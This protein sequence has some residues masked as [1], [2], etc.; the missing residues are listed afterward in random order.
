M[1]RR[2]PRWL[3]VFLLIAVAAALAVVFVAE[4]GIAERR[5]RQELVE[6][7][8]LRTGARVELG[9][10]HLHIWHLHAE[11]DNLTLHGLEGPEMPPLFHADRVDIAVRVLSFFGKQIALDELVVERPELAVRFAK[12]G[13]SNLPS[14][15]IAAS[16][17][18]WNETLFNLRIGRLELRNGGAQINDQRAPLAV[19]GQNFQFRLQYNTASPGTDSY[20]G[21]LSWV[22]VEVAARR[23]LPFRF[24]L[25]SK[26][27]L[28]RNAFDLDELICK[29]PNSEFD[30]RASLPNIAEKKWDFRYRGHLSLADVRTIF[31]E[32]ETPDGI[33]DFSGN[34]RYS[35]GAWTASGHY[36]GRDVRMHD[37]W[38]HAAKLESWGDYD[39]AQN[40]LVVPQLNVRALGGSVTGRLE[41]DL[42]TLE[43]RTKTHL[44]G[45]S[46][47]SALDAVNNSGFPVDTL[48]WDSVMTV[49][50][51]NTWIANFKHFRSKGHSLWSPSQAVATGDMPVGARIDYD[52]SADRRGIL[53]TQ[54]EITTSKTKLDFDGSL[55]GADS[56]LELKLQASDLTDWDDFINDLRGLDAPRRRIA[57][58][59]DWRGRILGPIVGPT[60]SGRLQATNAVYGTLK[61]DEIDGALEYSPDAFRLTNTT[62][63]RRNASASIDLSLQFD[64]DWGFLPESQWT[65]DARVQHAP[66]GEVQEMFSTK[67]PV[68]GYLS[69]DLRAS[70]TREAPAFDANFTLEGINTKGLTFDRL[71]GV[72]HVA[73]DEIRLSHAALQ[74]DSGRITGDFLYRPREKETEFHA[75]G[76]GIPLGEFQVLQNSKMPIGGRLDFQVRGSGPIAAPIAQG[77]LTLTALSMGPETEGNFRG[78]FSSDGKDVHMSIASEMAHGNLNGSVT[79][80][81]N[82]ARQITGSL[83]A[84]RID[85]DPFIIAGLHLKQL[86][87][88][89]SVSG[90][91]SVAGSLRQPDSIE[92]TANIA[93]IGFNYELIQLENDGPVRLIYRRNEVRIDQ[94]HLHG[95]NTDFRLSG[96]ARFDRDRPLH[97]ALSGGVDLRFLKGILPDL[98][99]QGAAQVNVSIGGTISKP[100]ITGNAS[101]RDASANYSDFPVGLSHV[102]GD[103]VFDQS[104][105]LFERVIAQSGGG[106][107][108]LDGSVTYGEG[109][110]RYIVNANT[111]QV[112]IRYPA[113]MS[114]LVGGKL[115]LAGSSQGSVLSGQI[116]VKR[117]LFSEGVD[118]A[119][120]FATAS[121]T[122]PGPPSSSPFLRNLT[123]DV[124]GRTSPGAQ[125][126]WTGAQIEIDGDVHLRG[127]WDRPVLLGHVHLLGGQMVFR[128]NTFDLTRGDINFANPFRLDPVLNVEATSTISQYQVTINFSG[129]ASRLSLNY[130]SDPPL[131]DSDIIALLAIGSPGEET[132]LRSQTSGSQNYGATALLSEAISS[133]LGGRIERLFGISHFRVDP[134]L[135]GTATESNAAARVTIEQQVTRDLTVT[136]SSNT[137]ASQYQLIEVDYAVKRDLSVVFLR[138]INGTYGFDVKFV[139]HFK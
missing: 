24:D 7:I 44:A 13:H 134:F 37:R 3:A 117:L 31:R 100:R 95:P 25:S 84:E 105:L 110:F 61:F 46:L 30:V 76:A 70:G 114:W 22:N 98:Q 74:K 65:L 17:R 2:L 88:H 137:S 132:A 126:Q 27:T 133:G 75:S 118:V 51:V 130:R 92:V 111:P 38:F 125:I 113:G 116:E 106:Q 62:V 135:A 63:R 50:S 87:G 10:F 107:L 69:G 79:I 19:Q 16:N 104:R 93:H 73:D 28:H 39:L 35:A 136:Y 5:V 58:K 12:D 48:H 80:G 33:A 122:T 81:L 101:V 45:V 86:T 6:Q 124:A 43:F 108:T 54:S 66:T 78:Q 121:E 96:S 55:S 90:Q 8:E 115:Q 128:G 138:D 21:N 72:L 119:S 20:T 120:F 60:F 32:S 11:M 14:P 131:P 41:M 40:R 129:P 139:K 49:D 23:D 57:G 67:Y 71:T 68:S 29:L 56:A 127:T 53:L 102:N 109:P 112:R 15:E 34:A 9:A 94:A 64:G 103:F 89:S 82:G 77:D 52:Y 91:F 18:S 26:F 42:S 4:T 123:F 85:M 83:S 97:L 36:A 59:V 47:A 99:A 1:K